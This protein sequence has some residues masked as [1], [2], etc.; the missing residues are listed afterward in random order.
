MKKIGNLFKGDTTIWVIFFFLCVISLVEVFSAAS[1]LTYKLG[2]F[3][4]PLIK[5]AGFLAVGTMVAVI[6][7]NVPC[8]IFKLIPLIG[9]PVC[10]FLLIITLFMGE[11][12]G[13]ARWI[14]IFGFQFQPSEMAKGTVIVS[15]ALVLTQMQRP[16]GADPRAFKYILWITGIIC[17]LIAPE[18]L[19]TAAILFGVVCLMM[20]LGRVP[21]ILLGKLFGVIAIAATLFLAVILVPS[22]DSKIYQIP[23][24][25]RALTW[26]HR[27][28]NHDSGK[29]DDPKTYPL[30]ENPQ[31]THATIAIANSNVAGRWPGNSKQRDFLPQAYSDFIFAIIAEEMGFEGCAF[32]VLLYIILLFRAGRIASRCERNFPAF[33]AMGLSLLLVCQA[34]LNMMV[35]THLFPVTGQPLPLISRG[36]TS[37][38]MTCVYFGM[39]L[40]VSRYARQ[41]KEPNDPFAKKTRKAPVAAGPA[42]A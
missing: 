11:V 42:T 18:N 38:L 5:Q 39:I 27:L 23:G 30:D 32:V 19:S 12:N 31:V 9:L 2:T 7:H 4:S 8:R 36:G 33:L 3:W 41:S 13:G 15:V 10:V 40:S 22:D 17:L 6:I 24:M 1:T 37:T 35:A 26:K 29:Q 25:G 20:F 28:V 16:E 34:T 21:M 14:P